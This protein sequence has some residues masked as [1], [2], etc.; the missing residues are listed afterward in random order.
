MPREL[1]VR[2]GSFNTVLQKALSNTGLANPSGRSSLAQNSTIATLKP[3]PA[4]SVSRMKLRP[5]NVRKNSSDR[6]EPPMSNSTS[7]G[8]A[9]LLK[10]M[11]PVTASPLKSDGPN[12]QEQPAA[13]AKALN[14]IERIK[15]RQST[16]TTLSTIERLATG[17]CVDDYK[18]RSSTRGLPI[19]KA[20][21]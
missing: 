13:G 2:R 7:P 4:T 21:Q 18:G 20:L 14:Y 3:T 10:I 17:A 19:H 16:R 11:K 15:M 1:K 12:Q 5:P 9:K 8:K 6:L